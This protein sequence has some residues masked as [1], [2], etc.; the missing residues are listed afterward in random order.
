MIH[1]NNPLF[2]VG[3]I[4]MGHGDQPAQAQI[5]ASAWF[6]LTDQVGSR[7]CQLEHSMGG[8]KVERP[9]GMKLLRFVDRRSGCVS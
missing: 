2:R 3:I 7:P 1:R 9:L 6:R 8:V 5:A 4:G